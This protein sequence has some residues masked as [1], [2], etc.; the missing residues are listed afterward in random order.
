[1]LTASMDEAGATMLR[2]RRQTR[3]GREQ[4]FMG[5]GNTSCRRRWSGIGKAVKAFFTV[6]LGR[7]KE[8]RHVV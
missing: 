6:P 5:R 8:G 3:G 7:K 1:M 4:E 2:A